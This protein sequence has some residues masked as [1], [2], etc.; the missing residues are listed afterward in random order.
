MRIDDI[1]FQDAL[2]L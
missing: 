2:F 1:F